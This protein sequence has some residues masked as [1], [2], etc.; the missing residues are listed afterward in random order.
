MVLFVV[1]HDVNLFLNRVTILAALLALAAYA[2]DP[3][4]AV[5]LKFLALPAGKDE[6]AQSTVACQRSLFEVMEAFPSAKPP[7]GVFF[8]AVARRIQ[9]RLKRARLPPSR[10]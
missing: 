1:W 4:E 2:S 7:L 3:N 9:P 10:K 6:Y 5:R 8:A